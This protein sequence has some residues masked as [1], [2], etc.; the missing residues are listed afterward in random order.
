[1]SKKVE[2]NDPLTNG[3]SLETSSCR[4]KE[5]P[6]VPVVPVQ[7]QVIASQGLGK[8]PKFYTT[9]YQGFTLNKIVTFC[10]YGFFFLIF[11]TL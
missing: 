1:M 9:N 3:T 2:P 10:F 5:Q 6:V 4:I 8:K 7:Q 11:R